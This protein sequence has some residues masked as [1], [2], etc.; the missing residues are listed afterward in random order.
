[1]LIN[2]S[3]Q[4]REDILTISKS[5]DILTIN[6]V[7]YDFSQL[8]EGATLPREAIDC[9]WIVSDVSRINGEIELTILLPHG[10]N[11]S[12]EARFPEPII[13][14]DDGQVVLPI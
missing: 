5:G 13:K 8:P 1:M 7:P 12:H 2:L 3:P 14:N 11:A 4:R 9:E 10:A 6:G